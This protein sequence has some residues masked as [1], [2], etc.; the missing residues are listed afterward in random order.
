MQTCNSERLYVIGVNEKTIASN[1]MRVTFHTTRGSF[2]ALAFV[3]EGMHKGVI[4]LG[5][6]T[7][8]FDGPSSVY[9]KLAED[10]FANGIAS[11]RL[12]YRLPGDC[13]QCGI[14]T[15]LG[16]QYM[17]DEAIHDIALI[18]WSFGGAVAL[19]AGSV[20]RNVQG[21]AAISTMD[22]ADC[23]VKRLKAKSVLLIH[24]EIDQISPID[25][26]RNI[27]ES[28]SEPRRFITYPSTGHDIHE[29]TNRLYSDLK[30]WVFDT[31][32]IGR[33]AA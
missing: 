9:N 12:D 3:R 23:C 21:I 32:H 28:S 14:D 22:V 29:Q 25:V 7:G 8:G 10:M 1:Q 20:A 15:L 4:M 18:G 5:G 33:V 11:L 30:S 24:G 2:D 13:V 19:A 26:S 27:Y 6:T 17:D 16:V 31:L